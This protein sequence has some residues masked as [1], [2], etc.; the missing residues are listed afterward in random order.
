M[1]KNTACPDPGVFLRWF[2]RQAAENVNQRPDLVE[3]RRVI[4]LVATE[5]QINQQY[6]LVPGE[7]K[8]GLVLRELQRCSLPVQTYQGRLQS[9]EGFLVEFVEGQGPR[10]Q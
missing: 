5:R 4:P 10:L 8:P 3:L 1:S 7:L 9:Q 6:G 2:E